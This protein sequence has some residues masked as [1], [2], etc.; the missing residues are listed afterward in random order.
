[1]HELL[2]EGPLEPIPDVAERETGHRPSRQTGWRWRI[3]GVAGGIKL[4]CVPV[5]GIW[6]TTEA[7]FLDFLQKRADAMNTPPSERRSAETPTE[8]DDASLRSAGLL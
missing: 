2:R 1:M 7:A 4:L 3:E 5:G 6:K 8:A